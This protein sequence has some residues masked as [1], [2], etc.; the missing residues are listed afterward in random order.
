[1]LLSKIVDFSI[2]SK[3]YMPLFVGFCVGISLCLIFTNNSVINETC[4]SS[5]TQ[6]LFSYALEKDSFL[7]SN[8]IPMDVQENYPEDSNDYDPRIN[9][10]GKPHSAKKEPHILVRP[11]YYSTELGI[12]ER[13]FVAVLSS[14]KQISSLGLAI[15]QTLAHHVNRLAFFV[16]VAHN[17]EEKLDVKA[18][19]IVGF[20]DSQ[21][22]LLTL[23]T[24][25]YLADKLA[26]GYSYF[27]FIRDTTYV[28]GRKLDRLVKNLSIT[29]HVYMGTPGTGPTDIPSICSLG[30][31]LS[32]CEMCIS[33]NIIFLLRFWDFNQQLSFAGYFAFA[34]KLYR[35]V[36]IQLWRWENW[37]LHS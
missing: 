6:P 28:D 9:L 37:S 32:H 16:D 14:I 25:K 31:K 34:R 8:V 12:K 13:S 36:Y 5:N 15:N 7:P 27:F 35:R 19:Q 30:N 20:K 23:H 26:V 17:K 22:G 10:D 4:N 2:G 11:R 18:L 29:E 1:M 33:I 24:L 3:Q 21:Q